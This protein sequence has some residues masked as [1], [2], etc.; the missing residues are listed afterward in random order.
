MEKR[1]ALL[2]AIAD[3]VK[4]VASDGLLMVG[5]DGVD[6]AGKTFFA[7][8]LA[9]CFDND[10]VIRASVDGFHNPR[11]VRYEKGSRSP[12][13][14]FLD[15]Y[16]Y[17]LLKQV[18]LDPLTARPP[19]QFRT[20]AFDHWQD[21]AVLAEWFDPAGKRLCIFDGI[22]LH[23]PELISYWDYS[24]F[25][26]ITPTISVARCVARE[27]VTDISVDP[28]DPVHQRYVQGQRRYI[29]SCDPKTKCTCLINNEQLDAP[30]IVT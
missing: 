2:S 5:I 10:E 12:T 21:A 11:V 9:A 23:R 7:D 6:G 13:G 28:S 22:F 17:A 25:L 8:E 1:Q 15:S 4:S 20:A 24:V 30:Y 16:N 26:D 18:L 3:E 27:G 19:R 14:F 29:D